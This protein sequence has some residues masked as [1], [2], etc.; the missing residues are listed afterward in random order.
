MY[1]YMRL[2]SDRS[3]ATSSVATRGRPSPR[4]KFDTVCQRLSL[5]SPPGCANISTRGHESTNTEATAEATGGVAQ[6]PKTS[7]THRRK[8]PVQDWVWLCGQQDR[9]LEKKGLECLSVAFKNTSDP[10]DHF[11]P[12]LTLTLPS[13]GDDY[14]S[15]L[16]SWSSGGLMAVALGSEVFLWNPDTQSLQG[17]IRPRA[18]DTPSV[19]VSLSQ[20]VTTVT[21]SPGG[22]VLGVGTKNGVVQLWDVEKRVRVR[23]IKSHLSGVGDLSWNQ[24]IISS[25]SVLGQIHHHDYRVDTPKVGVFRQ[26]GGVCRLEWSPH[27]DLLASG[28]M[29]GLL[30]IWTN[31]V[32]S[33]TKN[34]PPAMTMTQPSAVKALAWCPWQKE[35]I[36]TGGGRSDGVLRIWDNQSGV[37]V[38]SVQTY[39]QV[40]SVVWSEKRKALFTGHGLLHGL[41]HGLPHHHITCWSSRPS[42]DQSHQLHG[43]MGRVLHLAV[44]PCGTKLFSV[45]ADCLGY[46]WNI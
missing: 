24:Q 40:C 29:D 14:Y 1:A 28:S 46:V 15:H 26:E 22:S 13:L 5:D 6:F 9:F 25:G 20:R 2:I 31:D 33:T 16:V 23:T 12:Q 34:L 27:G 36:A 42:L 45:G 19:P 8:V 10:G 32:G 30:S 4:R 41:P 44:S 21:W 38:D 37:C 18:T 39:S 43:H 11:N 3:V 35:L 17:R 7:T